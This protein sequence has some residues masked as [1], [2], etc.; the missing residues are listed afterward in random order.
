MDEL[1]EQFMIE[2]RELISKAT[3][4]LMALGEDLA[5]VGRIDGA[6]RAVHTLKGSVAIFDLAPM[7]TALHAAEDLLGAV[8]SAAVPM[9]QAVARALLGCLDQCD[10]WMDAV[11]ESGH[12]PLDAPRDAVRIA[13]G[14]VALTGASQEMPAS[15]R[16]EDHPWAVD[17]LLRHSTR[18][19][20]TRNLGAALVAVRYLPS[21]DCFFA[22]DDPMSLVAAVPELLALEITALEPWPPLDEFDPY[23]CNLKIE[24]VTLAS[25]ADIHQLFRFIP[26][27]VEIVSISP[28]TSGEDPAASAGVDSQRTIRV[29]AREIDSLLDLIGEL[30]VTKNSFS[31]LAAHA[32]AGMDPKSVGAAIRA[33]QANTDRLVAD[34]HRTVMAVRM[35]PLDRLF[36]RLTRTVRELAQRL[37]KNIAFDVQGESTRVDK[38]VADALSEPLLHIVRNAIDHGIEAPEARQRSGK[39]PQGRLCLEARALG[40]QILVEIRDDGAGIDPARVRE[41][42]GDRQIIA[43]EQLQAMDDDSAVQLI[44]APGFSTAAMVTDVSG[45][46]VGMDAVKT[47]I[48]QLGG[49]VSLSSRLGRG[50]TVS[51]RLPATAALATVLLVRVGD[52]RF[53]IPL[54]TVVETVRIERSAILPVGL[55][56]AFVLRRQTLPL[57]ELS[58]LLG[59][60]KAEPP[61]DAKI[62]VIDGGRGRIG[63][64]V[65]DFSERLDVMLRPL[66]GLLAHI[67]GV[68]GTTL[69]GD[70]SVLLILNLG[71]LIG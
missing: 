70:G 67:P 66:T 42:A 21:E 60:D 55:G 31:L 5:A 27:Q 20:K 2:G 38:A 12:L 61:G 33:A 9:D 53:A 37:D 62:L 48:E 50:T 10:R 19:E 4:D 34:M 46:G 13:T 39:D 64:A 68:S 45:R 63:I 44:F 35:V 32:E 15:A 22:G 14:L 36:Q 59:T 25:E 7:G 47:A 40:D 11:E 54:E 3:D 1:F 69:L 17:L 57:I 41:V 56:R 24:F 71:E 43:L 52:E 51:L 18:L 8:R 6:F 29:S 26:D 23:R 30:V 65:D 28:A 58:A 16:S 49:R